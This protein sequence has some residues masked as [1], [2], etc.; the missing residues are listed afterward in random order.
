MN[1]DKD[2]RLEQ[3]IDR[4]LKALPEL[5]APLDLARRVRKAIEARTALPWYR[6]SWEM[7]PTP[8]R[9]AAMAFLLTAFGSLCFA[10]FQLT[11][12]AGAANAL[13]EVRGMFAGAELAWRVLGTLLTAL[14]L[15][16]KQLGTG[17]LLGCLAATALAWISC[18]GLGTMWV[19]LA[20][21][22]R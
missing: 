10:S 19:R 3:R 15:A 16:I 5:A 21:A 17:F 12:A 20:L 1:S 14:V 11:R 13:A 4:E 2:R 7:W 22:R 18:V 8:V 6:Q 9:W